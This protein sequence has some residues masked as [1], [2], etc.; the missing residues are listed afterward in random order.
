MRFSIL[1]VVWTVACTTAD[2]AGTDTA[3]PTETDG[4]G[5]TTGA[6]GNAGGAGGGTGGTG[7]TIPCT[8]AI[9]ATEPTDGSTIVPVNAS[10][11]VHF[12]AAVDASHPFTVAVDGLTGATALA[13]DGLSATFA[14]DAAMSPDTV[15]TARAS[16]C[17]AAETVFSFTTLPPPLDPVTVVGNTYGVPYADLVWITPTNADILVPDIE[18]LLAQVTGVD[19]VEETLSSIVGAGYLDLDGDV[20][21][22]CD[23]AADAGVADFSANPAVAMGP[24]DFVIPIG[25]IDIII[26]EFTLFSIVA[27]DGL[28]LESTFLAG[29]LDTR[30]LGMGDCAL[31]A[32]I[33]GG[34]CVACADGEEQCLDAKAS[35][36][37]LTLQ[38]A[39]IAGTCDL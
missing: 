26:E 29:R 25:G 38:D 20:T 13:A 3:G 35:A 15:Y 34:D 8:A 11:T 23:A 6:G 12:S 9:D 1:P 16:V 4:A 27:A 30:P 39:D 28:A 37:T 7:N 10:V 14:P 22:E 24:I 19:E 17:D 18:I 5:G 33:A 2:K 32:L 36:G 31:L 21:I